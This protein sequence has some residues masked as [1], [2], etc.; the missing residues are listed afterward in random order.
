[1]RIMLRARFLQVHHRL[2]VFLDRSLSGETMNF[3][4]IFAIILPLLVDQAFIVLLTLLNTAM[5]SSSGETAVAAVSMVDSLNVF[6][7]SMLI[8][9]ATGG[10]VVVAQY[11]GSGNK[12]AVSRA[13]AQAVALVCAVSLVISVLIVGFSNQLLSLLFGG[14]EKAV[15]DNAR[16]YLVGSGISYP[17]LGVIES[18]SGVLRGAGKTKPTLWLSLIKNVSYVLFTLLFLTIFN[19][20]II[21]LVTALL[22]SRLLGMVCSILYIRLKNTDF[23]FRLKDMLKPDYSM[24][25]R[26]LLLGIPFAVEQMFFNGGK[27]ITQTFIVVLGTNALTVN[28]ISN[29]LATLPQVGVLACNLAVVTVVGQSVGH[30]NY[31]DARKYIRSFLVIG[32]LSA[33]VLTLL[34]LP[35]LPSLI[36]LFSPV[37]EIVPDI[38]T[39]IYMTWFGSAF[40]WALSFVAPSALRAAGDARFTLI[41]SLIS[42]WLGR[43]V[44]GYILGITLSLGIAGV[45][46]AMIIEWGLRGLVFQIRLHSN[47]WHNH[48]VLT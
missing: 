37:A 36:G 14:A 24:L 13:A 43:V 27:L 47:K 8:A 17:L 44:L 38:N 48:S 16:L 29:S 18:I 45:W 23:I 9:L 6:I 5:V 2:V 3:K 11:M 33:L 40:L 39:I 28:A 7:L 10:A 1:M 31:K 41:V 15:L 22:I 32:S 4:Q 46:I 35:F 42:M 12:Q 19:L 25:R 20:G 26:V 34:L 30:G 21:G